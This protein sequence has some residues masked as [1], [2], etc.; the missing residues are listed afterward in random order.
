MSLSALLVT[1]GCGL[2]PAVPEVAVKIVV[3]GCLFFIS[4]AIQQK[5]VF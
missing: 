2:L 3:D 1:G 5:Y 4:Y